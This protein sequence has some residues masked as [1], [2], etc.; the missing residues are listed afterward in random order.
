MTM[1]P[2]SGV[3]SDVDGWVWVSLGASDGSARV[4]VGRGL[5]GWTISHRFRVSY[6]VSF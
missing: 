3:Q 5:P 1:L 2:T 6:L 4:H